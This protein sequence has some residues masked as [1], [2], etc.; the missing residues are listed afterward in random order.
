MADPQ[1]EP[2]LLDTGGFLLVFCCPVAIVAAT[3]SLGLS[4][5]ISKLRNPPGAL[6][7][8]ITIC[9]HSMSPSPSP[10][11]GQR[12]DTIIS[13][14][15][16]LFHS[17][18]SANRQNSTWK[19]VMQSRIPNRSTTPAERKFLNLSHGSDGTLCDSVTTPSCCHKS[20][21][22]FSYFSPSLGPSLYTLISYLT[23]L[24]STEHF[25]SLSH[26]TMNKEDI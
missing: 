20:H 1:G 16:P 7:P 5:C 3:P 18:L 13:L 17:S 2:R 4:Q 11:A 12:E 26:Q 22:V 23:K 19:Y 9:V 15:I 6:L 10:M 24:I 14:P 25:F 21:G 8:S